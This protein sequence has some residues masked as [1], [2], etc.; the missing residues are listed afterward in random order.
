MTLLLVAAPAG[1]IDVRTAAQEGAYPKF[2]A[3]TVDG[4]PRIVGLCIDIMRAIERVEPEIRFVGDQQWL[5]FIRVETAVDQGQLDIACGMIRTREREAK[6]GFIDTPMFPVDYLLVARADDDVQIRD[7]NEVRKLGDQGVILTIH[8]FVGILT[9][10][11]KLGGLRIDAGGRDA[12]INLDKLLAGRGRF[13]V[14]RTPGVYGEIVKSGLQDKVRVLPTVMYTE[15]FHM[16][17]A[18]SLPQATRDRINRALIRLGDSGE[19]SK[20]VRQWDDARDV[21]P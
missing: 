15:N 13:F 9:H 1:A 5:P 19:L 12:K 10:M 2:I 21:H 20:L 8:G 7:W 6:N 11:K 4:K 16:M 14:H 3:Q 17:V 18:R